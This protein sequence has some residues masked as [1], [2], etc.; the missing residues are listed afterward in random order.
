MTPHPD[1]DR[2]RQDQDPVARPPTLRGRRRTNAKTLAFAIT[3]FAIGPRTADAAY[4]APG[5]AISIALGDVSGVAYYTVDHDGYHVV[6]ALAAG[7][8]A[9]PV[10]FIAS[11]APG[12]KVT[13]STPGHKGEPESRIDIAR[14]GG[15]IV[16][17]R[18][19]TTAG[20]DARLAQ[21]RERR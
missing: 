8:D 10:R 9:T 14:I 19:G 7:P 1:G 11:L 3:A 12:Q 15:G 6:V 5:A 21:S 4:L 17:G 13:V 18:D 16:I 2:D 20:G